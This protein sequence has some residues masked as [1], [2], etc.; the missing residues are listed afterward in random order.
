[1]FGWQHSGKE[2]AEKLKLMQLDSLPIYADNW[3]PAAHLD[4]YLTPHTGNVIYGVGD[5][6]R[7]HQYHWINANHGGLPVSDSAIFISVSNYPSD[8]E[9]LYGQQFKRVQCLDSLVQL[10]SGKPTRYFHVFLM[11]DR[12]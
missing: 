6:T 12:K 10:R 9:Q 2:L 8:P 7:I 4:E 1:M 5:I 11:H 3:F